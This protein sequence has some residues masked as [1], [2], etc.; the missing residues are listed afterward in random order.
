[1]TK[2][3]EGFLWQK[4]QL[5]GG[6]PRA[7]L[8]TMW[9]LLTQHLA[10]GL[11]GRQEH[12]QMKV[13][14]FT[15]QRNDDDNEFFTFAVGPTKTRQGGLIAKIRLVT[16]KMFATGNEEGCPAMLFKRYLC[17]RPSERDKS[18]PFYLTVTDKPVSSIW[19]KK[20]PIGKNTINT[21][22][23]NMRKNSP[24]KDLSPEKNLTNHSA[25]KTVAKKLKS[26]GIPKCKLKNIIGHGLS[27]QR[28]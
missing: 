1:M 16:P 2:E 26:S 12:H 8:N 25:R 11:R 9:W 5:S 10:I 19:Y 21:I 28:A 7:L 3:E 6:T 27:C 23:K 22:M 14:D 15:L 4:G 24:L 18:G 20:T 17:K 13:E